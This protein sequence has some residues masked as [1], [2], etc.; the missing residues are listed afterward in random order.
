PTDQHGAQDASN[1]ATRERTR[2]H[3][4]HEPSKHPLDKV[5][6]QVSIARS[7]A[8]RP[9]DASNRKARER[10]HLLDSFLSHHVLIKKWMEKAY[11]GWDRDVV[12][13]FE[14]VDLPERVALQRKLDMSKLIGKMHPFEAV[15]LGDLGPVTAG[16]DKLNKKRVEYIK[17]VIDD[18]SGDAPARAEIF[19]LFVFNGV[20]DNDASSILAQLANQG[21][22]SE[23]RAMPH[24]AKLI[25]ARLPEAWRFAE[26]SESGTAFFTGAGQS[27]KRLFRNH[28]NKHWGNSEYERQKAQ[29]P[30]EYRDIIQQMERDET[31]AMFTPKNVAR[32]ALNEIVGMDPYD[33]YEAGRNTVSGIRDLAHG[34]YE[35][36]GEKLSV[37]AISLLDLLGGK[38]WNGAR[39][40]IGAARGLSPEA[41]AVMNRLSPHVGREGI[42]K[43]GALVRADSRAALLVIEHGEAGVYA[44]LDAKGDVAAAATK[45]P[46]RPLTADTKTT[47]VGPPN[48]QAPINSPT[49]GGM[50]TPDKSTQTLAT[51]PTVPPK[52]ADAP[53]KAELP[54]PGEPIKAA[55][56]PKVA[57]TP[58]AIKLGKPIEPAPRPRPGRPATTGTEPFRTKPFTS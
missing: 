22:I 41:H 56:Q 10:V 29:L 43:A 38:V 13:R 3:G 24:V 12:D 4:G 14:K 16:Q 31:V 52:A 44:L 46:S 36:A 53:K 49:A 37:A 48:L 57:E 34:E 42:E 17:Q 32:G 8:G 58:E 54:K 5:S 27:F 50:P 26:P 33:L 15:R 39:G 19:V 30:I 7:E 1:R 11:S 47:N 20:H 28:R 55:E 6:E 18:F 51:M 9:A 35:K 25:E 2:E 40:A 45:L 23:L 21:R